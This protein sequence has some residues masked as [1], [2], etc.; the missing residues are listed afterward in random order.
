MESANIA[1]Q[2]KIKSELKEKIIWLRIK[3]LKKMCTPNLP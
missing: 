2:E 1:E 3:S